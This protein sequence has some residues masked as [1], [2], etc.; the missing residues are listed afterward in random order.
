MS[1]QK[2][3]LDIGD[4]VQII[5]KRRDRKII[6][7]SQVL[8]IIDEGTYVISGPI[9][10]STIV[11]MFVS[12]NIEIVYII[13]DKGRYKFEAVVLRKEEDNVYKLVVKKNGEVKRLQQRSFY[14]FNINLPVKKVFYLKKGKKEKIIEENCITKDISGN[15]IRLLSNYKHTVNDIVECLFVIDKNKIHIKGRIVRIDEIDIS[16]FKYSLGI[17]FS[18]IKK[19]DRE[20]IVKYIFKKERIMIEKGLI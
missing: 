8:D 20:E 9:T 17:C 14:R 7:P 2:I 15:G 19:K 4:K 1:T 3:E 5:R 18:D 10:M 12:E 6:Y 16:P 11:P 13:K